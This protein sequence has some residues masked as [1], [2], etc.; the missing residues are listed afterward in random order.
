MNIL[1]QQSRRL[2]KI[3]MPALA[4]LRTLTVS[5]ARWRFSLHRLVFAAP[6]RTG[7]STWKPPLCF[8]PCQAMAST[9]KSQIL[10]KAALVIM[11][12]SFLY[13]PKSAKAQGNLVLNGGFDTSATGWTLLGGYYN[14]KNGN[15]PGDVV[16]EGLTGSATQTINGLTA[17]STYIVSG[18]YQGEAGVPSPNP[19]FEVTMDGNV[20]F[21]IAT[22]ADNN[23][24][25][26][27]F[28]Y[29]ASSSATVLSIDAFNGIAQA[30]SIDNISM[31]GVP[32]PA[33][34]ALITLGG[35]VFYVYARKRKCL[36]F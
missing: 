21:E 27:T 31:Q 16:L 36:C 25:N 23:W 1:L 5:A 4:A 22:P 15:P 12:L 7:N 20:L 35:G 10:F 28:L 9:M 13:F 34:W 33:A 26:F 2:T 14:S 3:F 17:G 32:E 19:S 18:S 30:Y 6:R 8:L 11:T 29:T 24:D